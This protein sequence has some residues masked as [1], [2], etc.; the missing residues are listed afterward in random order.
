MLANTYHL[1]VRPGDDLIARAG[2]LH[3]FMGWI[4]ADPDRLGRLSRS[5]AWPARRTV[6]EDGVVFQS[7]LDGRAH[8]LTPESAVDIQAR[9]GSDVAMM[10]DEC[11]S[12]PATHEAAEAAMARTL[13][14][15]RRGARSVPGARRWPR[16]GRA[17]RHARSGAVRHHPGRHVSRTCAT[18]RR[19][20]RVAVGFDGLRHRRAVGRRA[21]RRHVRH[22][23]RTRPPS[24]PTTG[25]A[26]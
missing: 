19:R 7:H 10:F 25:P 1:H 26:T 16:A 13:R 24:C 3:A 8:T 14:W 5:S 12:W 11:P 4:E 21:R 23:R 2:G 18:E 17:A 20:A 9:L 22:R 6:S 15:A